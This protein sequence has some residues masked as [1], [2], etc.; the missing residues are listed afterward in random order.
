MIQILCVYEVNIVPKGDKYIELTQYL[1][2]SGLD[3]VSLS[4]EQIANIVGGLPRS[5][6]K[7]PAYWANH[8]GN[9]FGISWINAGYK[10]KADIKS[11][12]A[13]FTKAQY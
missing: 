8:S 11:K 7:Y 10:V 1:K 9:S 6:Y 3:K 2:N 12:Q 4:F 5:A 13:V